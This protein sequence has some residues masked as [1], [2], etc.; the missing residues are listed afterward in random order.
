M[1]DQN[2][3]A[4]PLAL[5]I[6][7]AQ[8]RILNVNLAAEDVL[9]Q[10]R[11]SLLG[12]SL[13]FFWGEDSPLI[14]AAAEV[15]ATAVPMQIYDLELRHPALDGQRHN[16]LLSAGPRGNDLMLCF[17]PRNSVRRKLVTGRL[18]QNQARGLSEFTRMLG[19]EIK[20]PLAGIRGAAQLL[21]AELGDGDNQS[22]A[23]LIREEADRIA[24][25]LQTMDP[26]AGDGLQRIETI[27]V[28][29]V[30]GQAVRLARASY[31]QR[32][33]LTEDYDPSLPP[34]SG[35][36]GALGQVFMNLLKNACEAAPQIQGAVRVQTRYEPGLRLR[37]PGAGSLLH[38]PLSIRFRDNG[39][40][41]APHIAEQIFQTR[42]TTKADGHGLGLAYVAMAVAD[43]GG[44]VD[45]DSLPGATEF[46][47]HL[48]F[49]ADTLL[50]QRNKAGAEAQALTRHESR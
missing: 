22:L 27:N 9:Q 29:E 17:L 39:A 30:L 28:H 35:D 24:D 32:V 50:V 2:L 46:V 42:V 37:E 38:L 19:H 13:A 25:I 33:R 8:N 31:G 45:F 44:I 49:A 1:D 36:R 4:L 6:A 20:N 3:Q 12:Q 11:S 34:L 16:I 7:D 14:S 43:M 40:G 10:G 15:R 26:L 47:L 48:P 21:E 41:I 23:V 18:R 5:L